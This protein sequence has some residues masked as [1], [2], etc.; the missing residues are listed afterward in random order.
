MFAIPIIVA[1]ITVSSIVIKRRRFILF[2]NTNENENLL[3]L[4][5]TQNEPICQYDKDDDQITIISHNANETYNIQI[6]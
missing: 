1:G 5:D 2:N 3:E 4:Q 6:Q